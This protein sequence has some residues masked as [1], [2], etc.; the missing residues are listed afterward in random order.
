M[1]EIIHTTLNGIGAFAPKIAAALVTL[2]IFWIAAKLVQNIMVRVGTRVDSELLK[3]LQG[4][5][6]YIIMVFGVM[7]ALG[8]LGIDVTGITAGVGITGFALGFAMKDII[9]NLLSGVLIIVFRTLRQND[10]IKV[11]SIE[12]RVEAID[13]RYTVLV[14]DGQRHLIPNS[15]LFSEVIT[16]YGDDTRVVMPA[17]IEVDKSKDMKLSIFKR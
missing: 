8:K 14:M 16:I 4:I 10:R 9:S 2:L 12:G 3:F 7:S 15:K 1:L 11:G 5:V 6:K 17:G 13:L